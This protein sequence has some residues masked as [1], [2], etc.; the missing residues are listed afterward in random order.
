MTNKTGRAGSGR[1]GAGLGLASH[2]P[3]ST[4]EKRPG[5][6]DRN[7]VRVPAIKSAKPKPNRVGRRER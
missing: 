7:R 5:K 3:S 4:I 2:M 1:P 6:T